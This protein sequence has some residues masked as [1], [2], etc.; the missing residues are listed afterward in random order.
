[1]DSD[2]VIQDYK[3]VVPSASDTTEA[4]GVTA[5]DDSIDYA[6][7]SC[8]YVPPGETWRNNP[9]YLY[10]FGYTQVTVTAANTS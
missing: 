9:T 2:Y 4:L 6:G 1:V 10:M 8:N 3:D 5:N 7:L